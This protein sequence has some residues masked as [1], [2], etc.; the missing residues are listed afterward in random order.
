MWLVTRDTRYYNHVK[1]CTSLEEVKAY[2]QEMF[3]DYTE[4]GHSESFKICIAEIKEEIIYV[5]SEES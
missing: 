2:A 5:P 4:Y 1:E 3:S